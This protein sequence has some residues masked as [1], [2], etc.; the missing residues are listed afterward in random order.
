MRV[1][2][3]KNVITI[4]LANV[5]TFINDLL[6]KDVVVFQIINEF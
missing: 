5:L 3:G 1:K 6:L 2:M 4:R